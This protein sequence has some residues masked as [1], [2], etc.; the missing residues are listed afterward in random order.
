MLGQ[1]RETI[2]KLFRWRSVDIIQ[3]FSKGRIGF[4]DWTI[5][6][7]LALP[8]GKLFR[9]AGNVFPSFAVLDFGR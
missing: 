9:A 8:K 1:S 4:A 7:E 6:W 5:A 3:M 2:V